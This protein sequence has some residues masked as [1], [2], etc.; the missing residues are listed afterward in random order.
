MQFP[1]HLGLALAVV[2]NY[3]R[4][5]STWNK[6]QGIRLHASLTPSALLGAIASCHMRSAEKQPLES[7][8]TPCQAPV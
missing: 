3:K 5:D 6:I 7:S 4:C 8:F 1:S 2:L